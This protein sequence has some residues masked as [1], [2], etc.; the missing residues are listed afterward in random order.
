MADEPHNVTDLFTVPPDVPGGDGMYSSTQYTFI[1]GISPRTGP[2][3]PQPKGV[4]AAVTETGVM[5]KMTARGRSPASAERNALYHLYATTNAVL[6][7]LRPI[8]EPQ[9]D[10]A[11][12]F[13]TKGAEE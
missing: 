1:G 3:T 11:E 5:F 4:Q 9:A 8:L 6:A 13:T 12:P 10:D 7:D 2:W